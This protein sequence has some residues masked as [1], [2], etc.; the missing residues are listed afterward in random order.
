DSSRGIDPQPGPSGSG[1]SAAVLHESRPLEAVQRAPTNVPYSRRWCREA[2]QRFLQETERQ[3]Q[4]EGANLL[5]EKE[6]TEM[7]KQAATATIAAATAAEEF[8]QQ[9]KKLLEDQKNLIQLE[10][11]RAELEIKLLKKQL[12]EE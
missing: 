6:S 3:Q 11:Q 7:V 5:L 1:A 10:T 8:Y 2:S 9:S 4:L 12:G